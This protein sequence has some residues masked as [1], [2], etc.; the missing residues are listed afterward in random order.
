LY[1]QGL[2]LRGVDWLGQAVPGSYRHHCAV[3]NIGEE[4]IAPL[5]TENKNIWA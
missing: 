5:P 2:V 4:F 1:Q 3:A